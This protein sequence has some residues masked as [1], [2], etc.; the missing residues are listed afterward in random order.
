M[1]LKERTRKKENRK[2]YVTRW[3]KGEAFAS[4]LQAKR[5]RK[6]R[7]DHRE[8]KKEGSVFFCRQGATFFH[9]RRDR[10]RGRKKKRTALLCVPKKWYRLIWWNI[11][12]GKKGKGIK[13]RGRIGLLLSP[14]LV[15]KRRFP[16][17]RGKERMDGDKRKKY[18]TSI[19][20]R[21]PSPYSGNR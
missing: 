20:C 9:K 21:G 19:P 3:I 10:R 5:K 17:G 13:E 14:D 8:K 16:P 12:R 15:Q 4:V 7:V 2:S 18:T 6:G 11:G 1:G